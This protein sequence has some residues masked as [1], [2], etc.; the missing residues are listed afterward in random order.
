VTVALSPQIREALGASPFDPHWLAAAVQALQR[1]HERYDRGE[2]IA[3]MEA[4]ELYL[5]A[6]AADWAREAFME[7]WSRYLDGDAA[8]L[9]EAFGISR[10]K[11]TQIDKIR[12]DERVRPLIVARAYE[13]HGQGMPFDKD[14]WETI[15]R[16]LKIHHSK[17][18]RIF[19]EPASKDLR[20]LLRRLPDFKRTSES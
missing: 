2:K 3:L 10:R 12:V 11:R 7:S 17:V 9:D 15:G 13:L 5:V 8:N 1:C 4:V 19:G 18:E 14:M 20:E 16:E 6:F